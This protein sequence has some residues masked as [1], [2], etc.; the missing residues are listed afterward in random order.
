MKKKQ[1]NLS[2]R[3]FEKNSIPS[4]PRVNLQPVLQLYFWNNIVTIY[5]SPT[6]HFSCCQTSIALSPSTRNYKRRSRERIQIE[7]SSLRLSS[8]VDGRKFPT[9]ARSAAAEIN[10]VPNSW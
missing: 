2:S 5:P 10:Y 1:K 7:N 4:C 3:L 9:P 8:I 6:P